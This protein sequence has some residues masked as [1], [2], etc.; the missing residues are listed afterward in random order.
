VNLVTPT[1]GEVGEIIPWMEEEEGRAGTEGERYLGE[2]HGLERAAISP[3]RFV[4]IVLGV[5]A[6]GLALATVWA[7]RARR[8]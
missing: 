5:T 6:L 2:E 8:R 7:W 4:E 3:W 1:P